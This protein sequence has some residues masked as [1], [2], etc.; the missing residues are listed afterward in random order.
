MKTVFDCSRLRWSLAGFMP[1]TWKL[2]R[3]MELGHSLKS[4]IGPIAACVPGSVQ[5]ALLRAGKVRDWTNWLNARDLEWVENRHWVFQAALPERNLSRA[6]KTPVRLCCS[7][8]DGSGWVLVNGREVGTFNNSFVKYAFT[9]T[10]A[11]KQGK[12][13]LQIVFDCPPRWLGQIGYTSRMRDLKPRFN[14]GWDWVI[15]MVQIGI[16]DT[17]ALETADGPELDGLRISTDYEIARKTGILS[18]SGL[19]RGNVPAHTVLRVSILDKNKT[20]KKARFSAAMLKNSIILKKLPIEPWWPNGL[21]AQKLYRL[22]LEL[23]D[24]NGRVLDTLD[25][26]IGFRNVS[27][28]AC[29]N[30]PP[31][32][33]P[34]IC[35]VNGKPLFLQ[36]INWTPIRPNFADVGVSDYRKRCDYYQAMGCNLMRVWGGAYPEKECFYDLCDA[37]G[38]L[39][40]QEFPLS[41]SGIDNIPP[42]D[43]RFINTFKG[44]VRSY[45]T[46]LSHHAS[47]MLWC[48]GNELTWKNG[49]PLDAS[50]PLAA[51]VGN[52]LRKE[53]PTR[54]FLVTSSSGPQFYAQERNYGKGLHWDVHGP[55]NT[56]KPFL[57][58]WENYWKKDDALFRSETGCPGASPV[59]IIRKY[60]GGLPLLPGSID[61]PLW[62]RTSWWID[63]P[64]FIKEK[65]RKPASLK[66]FVAWSQKRQAQ[67]LAY[68]VRT[69]KRRFPKMGG[70]LLWMGHDSFPCTSNTSV[71]DFFGN[72]KPAARAIA[73]IFKS[74]N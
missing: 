22:R 11:L 18:V 25:R 17:M 16:W 51:A 36:G 66:E 64:I 72:P 69:C 1:Y 32:A 43:P 68:A 52:V 41:S 28:Q 15:R 62:R 74:K 65:K 20:V 31:K 26:S 61:N 7:G 58:H 27:W 12:N 39:V 57:K 8:L 34:W 23:I 67:A 38:F 50:H 13:Y 19:V 48:G 46:R 73:R 10:P 70:I 21:G 5:G 37:K 60:S 54:R 63:W 53:D 40:W 24:K 33:D 45:I 29:S 47:L 35:V 56:E 9:L 42:D 3:S 71:L 14:Y 44:I 59:T 2:G 6:G 55:W 49:V 30:A 4:E